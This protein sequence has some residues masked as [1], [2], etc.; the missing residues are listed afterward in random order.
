MAVDR[1]HRDELVAAIDRFCNDEITAFEFDDVIFEIRD[2]TADE[3]VQRVVDILWHFYDD[4]QDH[5][6]RLDRVCWNY[7]QRLK[8]LLKSDAALDCSVRRLWSSGQ[9]IAA[10]ALAAFLWVAYRAG[11]GSQLYVVAMPF[12][13]ISIG[14]S[15]WR[16][17]LYRAALDWDESLSPFASVG[18]LL[19]VAH[20]VPGF[21][22]ERYRPELASRRLR[23][24]GSLFV[25]YLQMYAHW[26]LFGPVVLMG[27]MLPVSIPVRK[28]VP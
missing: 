2:R 18:Q 8:L 28:V 21:R 19:W 25:L 24:A 11:L 27:Q 12:G 5:Q 17:R 22:K 26:L 7:F 16:R 14:L 9:L 4:C 1:T 13:L 10:L 23:D 3:T 20:G 15:V 6:V